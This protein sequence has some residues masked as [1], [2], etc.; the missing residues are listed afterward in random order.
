MFNYRQQHLVCG[1]DVLLAT[2]L[3]RWPGWPLWLWVPVLPLM[4]GLRLSGRRDFFAGGQLL[5]HDVAP[6]FH[7]FHGG[8]GGEGGES[9]HALAEF[10][11]M[12]HS[13]FER[14]FAAGLRRFKVAMQV[15]Q[16]SSRT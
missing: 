7:G 3:R 13:V 11:L 4:P 15:Y 1:L 9:R 8:E 12:C 6:G 2:S 16:L 14:G 5:A 10:C